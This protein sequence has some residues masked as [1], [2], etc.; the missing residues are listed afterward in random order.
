ML[1]FLFILQEETEFIVRDVQVRG[2]YVLHVGSIEGSLKVGDK[3]NMT[4][5]GVSTQYMYCTVCY[6]MLVGILFGDFLRLRNF[7][8]TILH[9]V[10]LGMHRMNQKGR[11]YIEEVANLFIIHFYSLVCVLTYI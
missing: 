11:F 4:I 7:R 3:V 1:Y 5:D 6:E 9:H 10:S 8:L 2:G